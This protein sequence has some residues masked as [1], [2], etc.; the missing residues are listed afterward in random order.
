MKLS[1][2]ELEGVLILEPDVFQD[3]RGFFMETYNKERYAELGMA[4]D[5]VQDNLS[6]SSRGVLRG[7]HYQ[8]P[9]AQGKLVQVLQGEVWDVA[10]DIRRGSPQFGRWTAVSLSARNRK[11][12]YVPPGFAHGF[13]VVSDTALFSY[14]CTELYYPEHEAGIRWDDADIGIQWPFA[15]PVLSGKDRTLPCL[16]DIPERRLP[17]R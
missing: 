4:C 8:Y 9:H 1:R 3:V 16:A 11:Q 12:L 6:F 17:E 13:C 14:K 7:L 15:E 10:V 2:T 5:F